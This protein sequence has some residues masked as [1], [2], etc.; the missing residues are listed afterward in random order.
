MV[1]FTLENHGLIAAQGVKLEL[2]DNH[3]D[4]EIHVPVTDIGLLPA[5]SSLTFPAEVILKAPAC[6][7]AFHRTRFRRSRTVRTNRRHS[8]STATGH[9]A[10]PSIW[11]APGEPRSNSVDR[12]SLPAT[13]LDF[14]SAAAPV[15]PTWVGATTDNR[16]V[17]QI[18]LFAGPADVPVRVT[19]TQPVDP[20]NPTATP[21]LAEIRVSSRSPA[22][23]SQETLPKGSW[24]RRRLQHGSHPESRWN[25]VS[26]QIEERRRERSPD[27]ASV[28]R[29]LSGSPFSLFRGSIPVGYGTEEAFVLVG[30]RAL[31]VVR[32]G[33]EIVL[34]GILEGTAS[35]A[36]DLEL[37]QSKE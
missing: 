19:T 9:P 24:S 8:C 37:S 14:G 21:D 15:M 4:Y 31:H 32:P 3:P 5:K 17:Y 6:R 2:P 13:S 26:D 27:S 23:W 16:A 10:P 1:N 20:A 22:W 33:E 29:S 7:G 25:P 36:T 28:I 12:Y 11:R 18:P 34:Q 30:S 35:P